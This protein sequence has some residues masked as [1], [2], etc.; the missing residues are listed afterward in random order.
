MVQLLSEVSGL[1]PIFATYTDMPIHYVSHKM[2]FR[3]LIFGVLIYSTEPRAFVARH[4]KNSAPPGCGWLLR[5]KYD[6]VVP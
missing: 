1:S 3:L 6:T 2:D 5:Y 4:G